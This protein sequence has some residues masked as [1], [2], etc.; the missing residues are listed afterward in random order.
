[1]S[2]KEDMISQS[3]EKCGFTLTLDGS[4]NADLNIE[5]LED[6]EMSF[7]EKTYEFQVQSELSSCEE[8]QEDI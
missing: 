7:A 1:M 3:F 2:K 4:E 8:E 6:Y 5:G